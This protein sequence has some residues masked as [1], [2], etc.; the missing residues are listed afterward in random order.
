MTTKFIKLKV[1][2]P[3]DQEL[4]NP[5][6]ITRIRKAGIQTVVYTMDGN[7]IYTEETV[8]EVL[9]KIKNSEMFTIDNENKDN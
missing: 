3:G 6:F 1:K 2:I 7:S 8:E 4:V 9:K 5:T